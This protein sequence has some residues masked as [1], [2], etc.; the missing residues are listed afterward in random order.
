MVHT[1]LQKNG[2]NSRLHCKKHPKL[3]QFSTFLN[4]IDPHLYGSVFSRPVQW[5]PPFFMKTDPTRDYTV[6]SNRNCSMA[7]TV[8]HE[9]GPNSRLHCKKHPKLTHFSTLTN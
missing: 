4:P 9:N 1:V 5:R 3:V 8:F 7:P 2:P 6:K